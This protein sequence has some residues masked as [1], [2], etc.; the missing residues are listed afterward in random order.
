MIDNNDPRLTAYVLGELSKQE[1]ATIEAAINESPELESAVNEIKAT[2][3]MLQ[4]GY[5]AQDQASLS[6]AQK[7]AL[8][9]EVLSDGGTQLTDRCSPARSTSLRWQVALAA[10]LL[11]L[12]GGGMTWVLYKHVPQVAQYQVPPEEIT[13]NSKGLAALTPEDKSFEQQSELKK[14]PKGLESETRESGRVATFGPDQ[15]DLRMAD[16]APAVMLPS[17]ELE[18]PEFGKSQ[19]SDMGLAPQLHNGQSRSTGPR[20]IV[21]LSDGISG[22]AGR[23]GRDGQVAGDFGNSSDR[24]AQTANPQ[25][26][27][28]GDTPSAP[29]LPIGGDGDFEQDQIDLAKNQGLQRMFRGAGSDSRNPSERSRFRDQGRSSD[30]KMAGT[31]SFFDDGEGENGLNES[32]GKDIAT[33]GRT[34]SK[35]VLLNRPSREAQQSGGKT[36]P[37]ETSV[38]KKKVTAKKRSWKRVKATPNTTRLMVGDHD[39]LELNGMQVN[40]QVDGFRAR[41]LIDCLYYNDRD[42]QLEGNFKLRLP[43]DASPWYFA[44]GQSVYDFNP[45]APDDQMI[46]NEFSDGKTQLVSFRPKAIRKRRQDD[47]INVKEARMVPRERAAFAYEQTIRRKV[48]PAL[49]EWSGAGVFNARVFPLAPHKMHRIVFGYDVNLTRTDEG[50]VYE[51]ALPEQTGHCVVDVKVNR[52]DQ[53]KTP[54]EAVPSPDDDPE[55]QKTSFEQYRWTNPKTKI[56]HVPVPTKSDLLL[57]HSDE[58]EGDFWG[59]QLTPELPSE[60]VEGNE[61]AI[62]MLDTS[63]SSKPEKFNLWLSLLKATLNNNRNSLKEFN[64][65]FFDVGSAFWRAGYVENTQSNVAALMEDCEK[66]S[67]EGATDLYGAVERMVDSEWVSDNE[68]GPDVFLLSDGAVTWGESDV[69]LIQRQFEQGKLGSVFAYQSGLTGTAIANLRF[70]ANRSGGTVFSIASE[71]EVA[72]ASTA[73]RKRPWKLDSID[74]QG[75]T[76]ILTAGRVEWVYPGQTIT[77]VGRGQPV[78]ELKL[79]LS[80]GAET[81][82][83]TVNPTEVR[84]ELAGRF[85]GQVAVGQLESIGNRVFDVSAAYARHFRV[86]GQTCSLLMLE[87]EQDY[88]RFGIK[89]E[90]DLF[91][92]KTK[93]A[94]EIVNNALTEFAKTL[95]DPKERLLGWLKRLESM[96]GM[97][98]KTPTA[99]KLAMDKIEVVAIS[100]P[101][102]VDPRD[103]TDSPKSYLEQLGLDDPDYDAVSKESQ[104]R[105]AQSIDQSLKVLS[106]LIERHPGDLVIARDVAFSAMQLDRPAQAY[107]LLMKVVKA[108]PFECSVYLAIAQ[109]LGQLGHADMAIVFYEIAL[110]AGFNN[111]GPDFKKIVAA[112]YLYLLTQIQSGKLDSSIDDF[113]KARLQTLKDTLGFEKADVL[114]T[115]M[116]NTDQTDVDLHIGEPGGSECSYQNKTTRIGGKITS[117]ITGGFGPEM[118]RLLDAPAGKYDVRVKLFNNNQSR[119]SLRNRVHLKIYRD[120]G[121]EEMKVTHKS[122][123]LEKKGEQEHV[124][125]VGV[126]D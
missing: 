48:D 80:Q 50:Y 119:A 65:L 125:T 38:D 9:N 63:L 44:F 64:V 89:P 88:E 69:R 68:N 98:F 74:A 120:F 59:V 107:P 5:Q 11:T 100:K 73:H 22:K 102:Q 101:L 8:R 82:S 96:P 28:F 30:G 70:L 99:L 39:E 92:V 47:W 3:E 34:L 36:K 112:D 40:V 43:D 117:D 66:I 10:S 58:Q 123:Q 37:T 16:Q 19:E 118:Y 103:Q 95:A 75:A 25:F 51:L 13:E 110:E 62:F 76:D 84:S 2:V 29:P 17:S 86:T 6:V 45:T 46:K 57:Q 49:V 77:V 111:Q 15:V 121:G 116:W 105:A 24:I 109:C 79:K 115:M 27:M 91:V 106:N 7:Q 113:A 33:A 41:V 108:R 67:L 124:A 14:L 83:V 114:I 52:V 56:V 94:G 81:Q 78:G 35:P 93:N 71:A 12:L 85:Y 72:A 104:R 20:G 42:Q 23:L 31:S 53:L 18:P 32:E 21:V 126:E 1:Q 55:L 61:R 4:T 54:L 90:E 122:V 87:T 97:T 26:D 60:S